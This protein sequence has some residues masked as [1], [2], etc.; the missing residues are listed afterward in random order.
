M[1]TAAALSALAAILAAP[2]PAA[3]LPGSEL[4]ADEAGLWAMSDRAEAA[5]RTKADLN[6]DPALNA[7]VR[8][9]ACRVAAERCAEIRVYVMD[10]PFF[11]AS[12]AP[13]GSMEVWS[14][15]LLRVRDESEL[16]FVLGHETSHFVQKDS[17]AAWRAAK[18]RANAAMTVSVVLSVAGTAVGLGAGGG[19]ARSILNAAGSLSDLVY[20]RAVASFFAFSREQEARADRLGFER[21]VKAGYDPAAGGALWRSLREEAARSDF[22]SVRRQDAA[23]GV[24]ASHPLTAARMA[25]LDDLA[26]ELPRPATTLE[27]RIR[28][29]AVIRPHLAAWLKDDL[30]R[31]DHGQTLHLIDRLAADG[32]DLGLLGF[33]R[34][35]AYRRRGGTGDAALALAAYRAASLEPDAPVAVWRELG[36]LQVRA[37]LTAQARASYE[38]Y[39]ARAPAAPDRWLAEAA[40]AKLVG[41]G[42]S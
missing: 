41:E 9:V 42:L 20:L 36:D 28:Y 24:F 39:L 33:Y 14:G 13:N 40:L 25:A 1:K 10:R 4:A 21:A 37:G 30:R 29:R 7:Y 35:E 19:S 32:E 11:N 22:D 38:T 5:G 17:L 16:A 34:G 27:D 26:A 15:L 31:R 18:M 23:A 6:S 3:A 8:G 12:M 2:A